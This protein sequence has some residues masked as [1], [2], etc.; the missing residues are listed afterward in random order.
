M[1][2]IIVILCMYLLACSG[3]TGEPIYY[4]AKV[5]TGIHDTAK[6]VIKDTESVIK[7]TSNNQF[8]IQDTGFIIQDTQPIIDTSPIQDVSYVLPVYDT[9]SNVG[10]TVCVEVINNTHYSYNAG[11][12]IDID[13]IT[14]GCMSGLNYQ[15]LIDGK[16]YKS[17]T[18]YSATS[19]T[20]TG[21]A[22]SETRYIHSCSISPETCCYYD[23]ST[24][25]AIDCTCITGANYIKSCDNFTK[26][27]G[28][29]LVKTCP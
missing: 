13:D 17:Y 16:V 18:D 1:K 3:N 5:D 20:M 23:S 22:S 4:I 21:Y 19:T 14:C 10:Y 27:I 11:I 26:T 15:S 24:V 7:D 25:S 12:K 9:S 29:K 6:S 8:I 28:A 2:Y